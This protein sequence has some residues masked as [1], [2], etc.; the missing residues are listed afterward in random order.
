[1]IGRLGFNQLGSQGGA[2]VVKA[3]E[4]NTALTSLE[5]AASHCSCQIRKVA[6]LA[7]QRQQP[8]TLVARATRCLP[9]LAVCIAMASALKVPQPSQRG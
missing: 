9:S 1:M 3:L 4:G 8:L 6:G 2:A 7:D 5:Y